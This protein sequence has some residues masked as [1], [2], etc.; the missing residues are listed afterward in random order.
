MTDVVRAAALEGYSDLVRAAGG[1]PREFLRRHGL[2]SMELD[3]PEALI[4]LSAVAALL[5]DTATRIGCP[6]LGLRL[7][8]AQ[9]PQMLGVL[10]VVL[11]N[12]PSVP[13]A[14][15]D[16]I[17]YLF[18]HSPAFQLTFDRRS[19]L[20]S[21]CASLR[22][23]IDLGPEV[24]VRQLI[25]GCL[26]ATWRLARILT[27]NHMRLHAVTLPHS[28]PGENSR[29][30][31]FF[32]VPV[33]FGQPYTGLHVP[34][35]DIDMDLRPALPLL[36]REALDFLGLRRDDNARPAISDQVAHA[37][38]VTMGAGAGGR[39][40]VASALGVHPRTLQRRLA[41]EGTSFE[42]IRDEVMRRAAGR[43]LRE[44]DLPLGQIAS[45]LG[46]SEQSVLTRACHRWFGMAPTHVRQRAHRGD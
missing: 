1:E 10:A 33:Y 35:G 11:L 32:G 4:P 13:A 34:A 40:Q 27:H 12:S 5:E 41:G 19:P 8:G 43:L 38:V 15:E 36:R 24:P 25:D 14:I 9:S 18:V 3:D 29:Y 22:F 26:G 45:I 37:L 20:F 21:G 7:S 28:P 46:Y 17:R 44:S 30:R 2:T 6:D 31:Q 39:A 16:A 23:E 42:T